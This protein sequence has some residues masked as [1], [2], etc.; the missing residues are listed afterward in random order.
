MPRSAPHSDP[1]VR[2]L[3]AIRR[4]RWSEPS[5]FLRLGTLIEHPL[6]DAGAS[7]SA[8]LPRRVKALRTALKSTVKQIERLERKEPP[9][10]G[11]SVAFAA[12]QLLRLDPESED[13]SAEELR[14]RIVKRWKRNESEELSRGGFRQY[15]EVSAV[16]EPLAAEF[17][18]YARDKERER[19]SV[20]HRKESNGT[21]GV[22]ISGP[23]PPRDLGKL[24]QRMWEYELD[25]LQTRLTAI[26]DGQLGVRSDEE[27]V[28]ML[29]MLTESAEHELKAV[30]HVEI[31]EWFGNPTLNQYLH[32]QLD[33]SRSREISLERIR[34]VAD[35]ELADARRLKQLH[36][37]VRLH[38]EAKANLLLCPLQVAEDLQTSFRPR[39]GLLLADPKTEPTLLTGWIG[40]GRIERARIYTKST[41]SLSEYQAEYVKLRSS[42]TSHER[43]RRVRAQLENLIGPVP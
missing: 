22:K 15:L 40:E 31:S 13:E 12:A 29:V 24:A 33:R 6:I 42:V 1:L 23:T 20:V 36:E 41:V 27:M 8:D 2:D 10:L 16:Y 35:D 43:D 38:D 34:L 14:R 11:R 5:G 25:T 21:K 9:P 28:R 39:M 30:D 37:F 18:L 3:Q 17:R 4:L 19:E 32:L 26:R 7:G